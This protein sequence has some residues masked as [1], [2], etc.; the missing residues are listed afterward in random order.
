MSDLPQILSEVGP[1]VFVAKPSGWPSVPVEESSKTSVAHWLCEAMPELKTVGGTDYG[2]LHRLDEGTSGVLAFARNEETYQ[3]WRGLWNTD[4]VHKRYRA[5]LTKPISKGV[6]I[7][8]PIGRSEKTKKKS[9][10]IRGPADL[11][12]IRGRPMDAQT[13]ILSCREIRGSVS[14]VAIRIE[15]GAPHQIRCHL[16]AQGHPLLGDALYG[17]LNASRL[18]LHLERLEIRDPES[19]ARF[20]IECPINGDQWPMESDFPKDTTP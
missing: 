19:R 6:Q 2:A 20:T 8:F 14:D 5:I 7:L 4:A 3:R 13:T 12:K 16:S 10:A 9:I 18:Y 11:R 1:L 17:G 15:T